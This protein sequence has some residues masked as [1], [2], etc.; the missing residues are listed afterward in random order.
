VRV[1][2]CWAA[3]NLPALLRRTPDPYPSIFRAAISESNPSSTLKV[4]QQ[5]ETVLSAFDRVPQSSQSEEVLRGQVTSLRRELERE[6]ILY[7]KLRAQAARH[8]AI[9]RDAK[10]RLEASEARERKHLRGLGNRASRRRRRTSPRSLTK[11]RRR[12]GSTFSC[13]ATPSFSSP[14]WPAPRDS[15]GIPAAHMTPFPKSRS[16]APSSPRER[17]SCRFSTMKRGIVSRHNTC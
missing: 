6:P 10:A 13:A 3:I 17:R 11:P 4:P 2:Y 12:S 1:S 8:E 15:P 16:S 9:A 14:R 5:T 7:G